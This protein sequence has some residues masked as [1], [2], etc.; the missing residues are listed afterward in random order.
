MDENPRTTRRLVSVTA[1]GDKQQVRTGTRG[2][3]R[4]EGHAPAHA[5]LQ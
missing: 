2:E 4:G 3:G 1:D 5:S